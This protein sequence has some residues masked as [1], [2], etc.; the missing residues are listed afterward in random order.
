MGGSLIFRKLFLLTLIVIV[1]LLAACDTENQ[2]TGTI[3]GVVTIGPISPVERP[4]EK[5]VI[6]FEVF[7]ARK[8]MIYDK[9]RTTLVK[10]LDIDCKGQ[11][12]VKLKPAIYTV[13]INRIGIDHSP[14]VPKQIE[15]R[16]GETIELNVDIDTG[17]R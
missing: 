4:G 9:N 3:Q 17:I 8:I 11:Y 15:V 13:D 7:Q 16:T 2:A 14:D 5:P 10:Q 1:P 6:H 12:S